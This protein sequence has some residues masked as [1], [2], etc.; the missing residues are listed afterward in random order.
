MAYAEHTRNTYAAGAKAFIL[1]CLYFQLYPIILGMV[2]PSD[3]I[4]AAFVGF[5][6]QTCCYSSLKTYIYGIRHW[7]LSNGFEFKPW[8]QRHQVY[9][10]MR[11]VRRTFGDFVDR[12]LAVTPAI[13]LGIRECL[14]LTRYND[15]MLWCA[16]LVAFWGLFRKDN[17]SVGKASAFNPR[18]NLT[19]GD[20]SMKNGV[21][22]VRVR[23]SKTNQF[24]QRCHWVPLVALPGNPLCP[25]E[26]VLRVF[27]LHGGGG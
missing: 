12:K 21:L 24:R 25:V 2:A 18:A 10:A 15:A 19:R 26:A 7:V 14:D 1:F 11:G 20:F 3:E 27:R 13:L 17:I 9:M 23:H 22:W 5:Q 4:L 16:M 6:S 8:S